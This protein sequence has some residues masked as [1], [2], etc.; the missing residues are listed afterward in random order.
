M[1]DLCENQLLQNDFMK[2]FC[3]M[4]VKRV[5]KWLLTIFFGCTIA[6]EIPIKYPLP[7]QE[8]TRI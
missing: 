6:F 4:Q 3:E 5:M 8:G 7:S 1:T 2:T